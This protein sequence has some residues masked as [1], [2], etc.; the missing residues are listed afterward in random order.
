[1]RDRYFAPSVPPVPLELTKASRPPAVPCHA[2]GYC[3]PASA[4][5]PLAALGAL[6]ATLVI[7][8]LNRARGR[9]A[10]LEWV[11]RTGGA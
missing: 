2:L 3:A 7:W 1:M 6:I 4:N 9:D 5:A 8:A 10:T 11:H